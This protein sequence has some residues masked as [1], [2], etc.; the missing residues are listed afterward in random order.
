MKQVRTVL[1]FSLALG[2]S[3]AIGCSAGTGTGAATFDG[4]DDDATASGEPD[5]KT[6]ADA[7]VIPDAKIPETKPSPTA[8][9]LQIASGAYT[10]TTAASGGYVYKV[11]F[12]LK[13]TS[14]YNVVSL[15]TMVFDFGG[16]KMVS[17]S[18][19]ACS[20]SFPIPAGGTKLVDVQVVIS[21]GGTLS[22]FAM[23]CGSSQLFGGASGTAPATSTFAGTIEI[24]V[25]GTT[26]TG[27]FDGVGSAT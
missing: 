15:D 23:I 24:S 2:L 17:L 18:E 8:V 10:N 3:I 14:Q 26:N 21:A 27:T 4:G 19:P 22:N 9:S 1:S 7:K 6:V 5:V 13:N 20:G 16:G 12:S 25:G 11:T